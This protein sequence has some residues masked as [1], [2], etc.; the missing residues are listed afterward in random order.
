M[1][2]PDG[3]ENPKKPIGK[4]PCVTIWTKMNILKYANDLEAHGVTAVEQQTMNAFPTTLKAVGQL[5]RWRRKSISS[6]WK[7]LPVEI[8]KHVKEIPNGCDFA[9]T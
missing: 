3:G 6:Q 8:A 9:C 2:F 5:G 7:R 1:P 4:Q